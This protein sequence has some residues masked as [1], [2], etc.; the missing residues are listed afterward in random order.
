VT[1]AIPHPTAWS[2]VRANRAYRI[3]LGSTLASFIGSTVH[4]VAAAWLILSLTGQ[5]YSVPLLLLFSA[6]PGVLLSPLIGELVDRIESRRLLVMVDVVSAITVA[7]LPVI[8]WT[9]HLAPWHLY[10]AEFVLAFL[11]QLYGPASKVLVRRLARPEELLAANATVTL[12][13]QLGIA[14]GALGGG[15]LIAATS[16]ATGLLVNAISFVVSAAGLTLVGRT[17]DWA[18][19]EQVPSGEDPAAEVRQWW[20]GSVGRLVR[21]VTAN[22]IAKHMTLL[23]LWLQCVHRLLASL[24]APFV[25]QSGAGPAFQGALQTGYSLGAVAAGAAI[26]ILARRIGRV[27]MLLLGSAGTAAL[28]AVFPL[29]GPA[30]LAVLVYGGAGLAVSTWVYDLTAAQEQVPLDRQ[31]RY[32]AAT[33]A[34]QSLGGIAVFATGVVLLRVFNASTIYYLGAAALLLASLPS[35]LALVRRGAPAEASASRETVAVP[36]EASRETVAVR[37]EE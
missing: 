26:P 9:G 31:G 15:V 5:A 28:I 1:T 37:G 12:V 13:Y 35:V 25:V 23:F 10:V 2:V 18:A 33:G 32:F 21:T 20:R 8:S 17:R 30:W 3:F 29:V 19:A 22:R 4:V 7:A 24:L 34:L 16:P 14:L 36:A 11:G 27:G 6:L